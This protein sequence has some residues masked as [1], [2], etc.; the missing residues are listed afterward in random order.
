MQQYFVEQK[1]NVN[2]FVAFTSEQQHHIAH[3]LRM[4][5]DTVV[6]IVDC[7]S[8]A[9]LAKI[10]YVQSQPMA[11]VFEKIEHEIHRNIVL[12]PAL[13]KKDKWEYVLQ[14]AA[15][16]GATKILPLETSR[17]VVK[18][19]DEK[20]E[21]KLV[22]WNKIVMEACEQ[23]HHTVCTEVLAPITIKE[24]PNYLLDVNLVAYEKENVS[25]HIKH[26]VRGLCDVMIIIG[27]EGGFDSKEI[28][29][30]LSMGI[31][32]CSLGKNILRAETAGLYALS[33]IDAMSEECL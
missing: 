1:C 17:T 4:K 7:E 25:K 28:D 27:P 10:Q 13:I 21:K 20:I 15:E 19:N 31:Q 11:V 33:V 23:S 3:V 14:K 12:V 26:Y 22:R 16:L 8:I 2:E 29:T 32:P 24:L 30:M 18:S 9:Y 5:T 6:R